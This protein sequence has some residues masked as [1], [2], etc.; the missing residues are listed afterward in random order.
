MQMLISFNRHAWFPGIHWEDFYHIENQRVAGYSCK[1]TRKITWNLTRKLVQFLMY[2][3][4][5]DD[6]LKP[7]ENGAPLLEDAS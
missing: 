5:A 7:S 4:L 1:M 6:G 3:W 2:I